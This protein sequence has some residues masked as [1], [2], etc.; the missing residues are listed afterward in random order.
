MEVFL[1]NASTTPLLPQVKN[2]FKEM[3]DCY[4]NPSSL[5]KKGR[6]ARKIIDE[7]R[8]DVAK[9]INA[10]LENNEKI[11]FTPS[12][13]AANTIMLN[14]F[15]GACGEKSVL[16]SPIAH[17][18]ILTQISYLKNKDNCFV[19]LCV[20]NFGTI[21]IDDFEKKLTACKENKRTPCVV[22]DY[23]NSEIG[24]IQPIRQIIDKA[25]EYGGVVYLD[26]TAVVSTM[27]IDVRELQA[28]AIGFSGH[29]IGALKG[30]GVL[31]CNCETLNLEPLIFG[32]QECG[33]VGGTENIF[34]IVSI[35]EAVRNWIY[36]SDIAQKRD[37]LYE[38]LRLYDAY[39]V[40]EK[41]SRLPNNLNMCFKDVPGELLMSLLDT[42]GVYVSTGSACNSGS[43]APSKVLQEI[44]MSTNDI[45]SCIR[46]T[47]S[48][49][50]SYESLDYVCKCI[51]FAVHELRGAKND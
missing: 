49:N 29:K 28:D 3:L 35:G 17:K 23:A 48:G 18:S 39:I 36:S 45:N 16:F 7:A 14:S 42:M 22:V 34:G 24:T 25:H 26:C 50:E 27:P 51:E 47:L 38:K 31:W 12:G 8:C 9:F 20:N 19:P 10:D 1:D 44:K 37:Y 32:A 6:E 2:K 46:I 5:H 41:K 40:G 11:I 21:N 33:I 30:V 15:W 43:N 4:G 13:S